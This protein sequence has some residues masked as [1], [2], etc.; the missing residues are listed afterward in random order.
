MNKRSP[1]TFVFR[2]ISGGFWYFVMRMYKGLSALMRA[3]QKTDV[4]QVDIRE[5]TKIFIEALRQT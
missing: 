3:W 5:Y 4:M 1:P 2:R